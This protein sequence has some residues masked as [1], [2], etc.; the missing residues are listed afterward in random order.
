[1]AGCKYGEWEATA[2]QRLEEWSA[3]DDGAPSGVFNA[4]PAASSISWDCTPMAI[5]GI[6]APRKIYP[7]RLKYLKM[8]ISFMNTV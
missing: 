1:M 2:K 3:E 7:T 6:T 5:C 4:I 8:F